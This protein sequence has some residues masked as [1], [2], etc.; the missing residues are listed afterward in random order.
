[1]NGMEQIT[2]PIINFKN[3]VFFIKSKLVD[4]IMIKYD[5]RQPKQEMM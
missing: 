2:I 1:V 4:L 3:C 5:A